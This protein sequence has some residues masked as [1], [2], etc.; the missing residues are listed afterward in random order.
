MT[1]GTPCPHCGLEPGSGRYCRQCGRRTVAS[2]AGAEGWR[3]AGVVCGVAAAMFAVLGG[4]LALCSSMH[5]GLSDGG[6]GVAALQGGA[7]VALCGGVC[8][9]YGWWTGR[10]QDAGRRTVRFGGRYRPS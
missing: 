3:L 10:R 2:S 1:P 4:V 5:L 6:A 9:G 8:W 7:A